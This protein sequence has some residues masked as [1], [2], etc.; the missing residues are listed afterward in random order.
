[1]KKTI[2]V[3]IMV[4]LSIVI[5][6]CSANNQSA[7]ETGVSQTQQINQLQ[8]QAAV[9][10]NKAAQDTPIANSDPADNNDSNVP[11]EPTPE[12]SLTPVDTSTAT[13]DVAL[14][15]VSQNTNCRTGPAVY[16][17]YK[18]T[19]SAGDILEVVGLPSDPSVTEYVI[20]K[21][22]SGSGNCWL[23]TRYANKT[24]FSAYNLQQYSTPATPTP[25]FTPTPAF[26][27]A[28]TWNI[29]VGGSPY[30]VPLTVSGSTLSGIFIYAGADSVSIIG[31]ISADGQ[32]V[33]GNFTDTGGPDGTFQWS[34]KSGNVNQFI[35]S[36]NTGVAFEW[37]GAKNGASI[38]S[39][40][41]WP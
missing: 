28:S 24:D 2:V 19:V 14:I 16:F 40:C 29:Q 1:M 32:T 27:W 9:T 31:S 11:E 36:G 17:G 5:S 13:A 18:S 20:V 6:A 3:S 41:Q 37:C 38:P 21:N 39:P 12:P 4:L 23:W 26:D 34:I 8:T 15:S 7:I 10:G 25:T 22:P 33:S 35:G 30:S